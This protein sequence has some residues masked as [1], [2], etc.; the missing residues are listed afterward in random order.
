MEGL[1]ILSKI[2]TNFLN[3]SSDEFGVKNTPVHLSGQ[4]RLTGDRTGNKI[5]FAET[6]SYMHYNFMIFINLLKPSGNFTYDQV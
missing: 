1:N 6:I 2:V 4:E 5:I 3:F